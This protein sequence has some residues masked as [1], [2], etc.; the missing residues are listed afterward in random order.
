MLSSVNTNTVHK[1]TKVINDIEKINKTLNVVYNKYNEN[2]NNIKFVVLDHELKKT[3]LGKIN[4][5]N[6]YAN[7][8]F[9]LINN[10]ETNKDDDLFELQMSIKNAL[11][12]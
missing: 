4:I 9:E 7:K 12:N 2:T 8:N 10:L 5:S 11:K 1:V 6:H 3:Y